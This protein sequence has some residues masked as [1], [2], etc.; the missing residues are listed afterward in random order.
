MRREYEDIYTSN[1]LG[2]KI[3]RSDNEQKGNKRGCKMGQ[4][5]EMETDLEASEMNAE[6]S[7]FDSKL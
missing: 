1:C 6:A 3:R 5:L 2:M 4:N 7:Y